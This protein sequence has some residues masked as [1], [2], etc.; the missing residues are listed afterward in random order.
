MMIRDETERRPVVTVRLP[1]DIKAWFENEASR[2]GGSLNSEI[3]RS[4]RRR[5]DAE[6]K[7]AVG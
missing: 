7:K 3:I 1:H 5:M 4:L 6:P 2:N